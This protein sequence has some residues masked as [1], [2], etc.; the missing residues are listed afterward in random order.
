VLD[1]CR[2][3][4]GS[5]GDRRRSR[6]VVGP[7]NGVVFVSRDGALSPSGF[8]SIV[9]GNV[10]ERPLS[11]MRAS[12]PPVRDPSRLSGRC[13]RSTYRE[14]CGGSRPQAYPAIGGPFA[15]DPICAH[16]PAGVDTSAALG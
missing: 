15:G 4:P 2:R 3:P 8:L 13:G 6:L 5:P 12:A 11:E 10:G 7:G 1:G 16:Q 9:V 14:I